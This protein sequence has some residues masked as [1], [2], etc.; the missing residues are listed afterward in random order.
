MAPCFPGKYFRLVLLVAAVVPHAYQSPPLETVTIASEEFAINPANVILGRTTVSAGGPAVTVDGAVVFEDRNDD[1]FVKGVEVLTGL[2]ATVKTSF[3]SSPH[4]TSSSQCFNAAANSVALLKMVIEGSSN[5][6]SSNLNSF[7]P[8]TS[9]R[10]LLGTAD[11]SIANL[12]NI[13]IGTLLTPLCRIF[14]AD[15]IASGQL[16]R[17]D[18]VLCIVFCRIKCHELRWRRHGSIISK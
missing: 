3:G 5:L 2:T 6:P 12:K 18:N 1:V 15:D 9:S 14:Y 8:L 17:N 4:T 7:A 11:S 13:L 10:S 16:G